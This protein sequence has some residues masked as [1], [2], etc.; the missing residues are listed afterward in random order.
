MLEEDEEAMGQ[1]PMSRKLERPGMWWKGKVVGWGARMDGS[2]SVG[3]VAST[4]FADN[5]VWWWDGWIEV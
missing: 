3:G 4:G 5:I 2:E 1:P